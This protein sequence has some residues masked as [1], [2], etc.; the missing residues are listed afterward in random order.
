MNINVV[1]GYGQ[2]IGTSFVM[3]KVKEAGLP[4]NG[5]MF[6]DGLTVNKHN[7][8]GYWEINPLELPF[9]LENNKLDNSICKIWP[10]VLE[11]IEH[12]KI[13][14]VVVLKR[15]NKQKQLE[16]MSKVL[17]DELTLPI[18]KLFYS[19]ETVEFLL[20]NSSNKLTKW[21]EKKNNNSIL[22]VYT[23]DLDLKINDIVSFLE[24]GLKCH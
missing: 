23:E 13:N 11:H 12:T 4:I 15:K 22:E 17:K 24:R 3:Q 1:T 6:L 19:N 10:N 9:L 14:N 5:K 21:L 7:P 16:S 8:N 18:N 2:R 20:E